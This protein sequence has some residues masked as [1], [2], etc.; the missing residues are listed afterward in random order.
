MEKVHWLLRNGVSI[1][2]LNGLAPKTR[3]KNRL[4]TTVSQIKISLNHVSTTCG[5]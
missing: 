4:T 2:R 1:F 5:R 3:K